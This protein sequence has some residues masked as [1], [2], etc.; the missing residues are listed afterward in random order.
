MARRQP[1][2]QLSVRGWAPEAL[3]LFWTGSD[4][5]VEALPSV[6]SAL[7]RPVATLIEFIRPFDNR[8]SG[9]RRKTACRRPICIA[10]FWLLR[11]ANFRRNIR[12]VYT[13]ARNSFAKQLSIS[14]AFSRL[15][16]DSGQCGKSEYVL[17]SEPTFFTGV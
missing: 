3:A 5:Q 17:L 4:G 1:E 13:N 2:I 7:I 6:A 14:G 10:T 15:W 11:S 9:Y 16:L 12:S 8:A